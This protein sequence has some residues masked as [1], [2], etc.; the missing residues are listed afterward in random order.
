MIIFLELPKTITLVWQFDLAGQSQFAVSIVKRQITAIALA[1]GTLLNGRP[2]KRQ[3]KPFFQ[4]LIYPVG[5]TVDKGKFM[6][7]LSFVAATHR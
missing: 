3:V 7:L 2:F 6:H 5:D 4:N 1:F